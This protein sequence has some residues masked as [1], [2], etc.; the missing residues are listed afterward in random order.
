MKL[1]LSL[2]ALALALSNSAGVLAADLPLKELLAK[3]I[4]DGE[5]VQTEVQAFLDA[6]VPRIQKPASKEEWEKLATKMRAETLE[7]VVFRGEAAKW[8]DAPGKVE[9]LETI[10]GGEGYKIK[11]L[12]YEAIPGIW[13]PALLYEPVKL[14]G[15]HAGLSQC[16]RP[17]R[18]REKPPTTSR[19]AASILPNG[20]SSR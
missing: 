1:K 12:R 11:K 14:D 20:E 5:Q 7:K 9:W 4:L 3:P 17:R 16:E 6:R 10:E 8:R 2:L 13:I 18:R 19:L 15:K